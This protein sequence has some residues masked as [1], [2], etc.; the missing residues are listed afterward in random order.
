MRATVERRVSIAIL[1]ILAL[2]YF[3]KGAFAAG[4]P[5]PPQLIL[6]ATACLFGYIVIRLSQTMYAAERAARRRARRGLVFSS[7]VPALILVP[8]ALAALP[9]DYWS[10]I[11]IAGVVWI[12]LAMSWTSFIVARAVRRSAPTMQAAGRVA[13]SLTISRESA[14]SPSHAK[15][16]R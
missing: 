2:M 5:A 3:A 13:Q 4:T 6:A 8:G 11:L 10:N 12:A 9:R 7:A 15:S 16:T 14:D 1:A